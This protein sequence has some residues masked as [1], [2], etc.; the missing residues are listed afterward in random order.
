MHLL[1]R[2]VIKDTYAN[3][4]HIGIKQQ[5]PMSLMLRKGIHHSF[6]AGRSGMGH[7]GIL[8]SA[9]YNPDLRRLNSIVAAKT[10]GITVIPV[11]SNS[12]IHGLGLGHPIQGRQDLHGI[13]TSCSPLFICGSYKTLGFLRNR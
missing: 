2:A 8:S 5:L 13:Q 12:L 10:F 11:I 3:E 1:R 4:T 7:S 6:H 9:A